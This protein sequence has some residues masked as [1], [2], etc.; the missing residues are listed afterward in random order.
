MTMQK[1]H[2]AGAVWGPTGVLAAF[3]CGGLLTVPVAKAVPMPPTVTYTVA[4]SSGDFT[5]DFTVHNNT[6]QSLYFFGVLL[7]ETD[8]TGSPS[9]D[10]CGPCDTPWSNA[11]NGGSNIVYNNNWILYNDT[12]GNI[13]P[14]TSLDGFTA[15]DTA[16]VAPASIDWFAYTVDAGQGPYTG[17]GS[18]SISENPGFEGTATTTSTVPEPASISLFFTA[19]IGVGLTRRGKRSVD[20]SSALE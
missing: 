6:N 18:F 16:A 9:A 8:V 12:I 11:S 20:D 2:V 1:I 7:P 5:L 4:G 17:V 13:E 15:L 19:I 14:G 3:L 10:W